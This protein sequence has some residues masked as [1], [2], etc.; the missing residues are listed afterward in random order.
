VWRLGGQASF[1]LNPLTGI[2]LGFLATAQEDAFVLNASDLAKRTRALG[3]G[4]AYTGREDFSL[5]LEVT[6]MRV[7]LVESDSTVDAA[8]IDFNIRYF[9]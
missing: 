2:P 9:F 1:D 7:P 4:V 3:F 6:R 5:S 8:S